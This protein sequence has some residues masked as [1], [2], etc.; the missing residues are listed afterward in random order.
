MLASYLARLLLIFTLTFI[1]GCATLGGHNSDASQKPTFVN[2]PEGAKLT[3]SDR[4]FFAKNSYKLHDKSVEVI[5]GL[6]SVFEKAKGK[7]IIEGHTD[8]SG[9]SE[10]NKK[11]SK[12]R[13]DAVKEAVVQRLNVVPSRIK[14]I[15]YGSSR[16]AIANAKTSTELAENRRAVF[17]FPNETVES[18]GGNDFLKGFQNVVG[19][20]GK[21]VSGMLDSATGSINSLLNK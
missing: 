9:S 6:K 18:L 3:V 1:T 21:W 17:L 12:Q 11:L 19:N 15:G 13:A 7:V 4:V 14:T 16:P 10:Y 8:S 2:T 20:V 5:D